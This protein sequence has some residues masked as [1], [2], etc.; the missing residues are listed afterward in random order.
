MPIFPCHYSPCYYHYIVAK[1]THMLI[2]FP[3]D[4][5]SRGNSR[6]IIRIPTHS[7]TNTSLQFSFF[8]KSLFTCTPLRCSK[9]KEENQV[10]EECILCH[11]LLGTVCSSSC[12]QV[13]VS[14]LSNAVW[15]RTFQR[16]FWFYL[17]LTFQ[18]ISLSDFRTATS[19][20]LIVWTCTDCGL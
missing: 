8:L 2:V 5:H 3:W 7:H 10:W 15:H 17:T 14:R 4:S 20:Q 13:T 11:P 12:D 19:A 9:P 18:R 1:T 16:V 6:G